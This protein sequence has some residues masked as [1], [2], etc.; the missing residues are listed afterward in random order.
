[1][2]K[3][4]HFEDL[5]VG[6]EFRS[7]TRTIAEYDLYVFAGLTGDLTDFHISTEAAKQSAFG[8]RVAHGMLLISIANGL[9]NRIGITDETGLALAGV[10]WRFVAPGFI[11]DTIH[12]IASV[13]QKREVA[14][15]DRGLVFWDVRLDKQDGTTLCH[16]KMIRMVR[17]RG[18]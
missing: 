2:E 3:S 8:Q 6:E 5:V 13:S 17:R 18:N 16:G 14:K 10:E 1:M 11:G 7:P 4:R 15:K 9:Y 12:L